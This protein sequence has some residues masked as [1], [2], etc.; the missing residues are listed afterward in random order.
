MARYRRATSREIGA[1][2]IDAVSAR[3]GTSGS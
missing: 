3:G 2:V 1:A